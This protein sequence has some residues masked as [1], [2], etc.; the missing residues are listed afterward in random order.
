MV[1]VVVVVVLVARE[2]Q[3]AASVTSLAVDAGADIVDI[4]MGCPARQVTRGLSGSA[5]MRDLD[6]ALTLIEATVAASSV[7]VTL[8]MRLVSKPQIQRQMIETHRGRAQ[9]SAGLLDTGVQL[10]GMRR[11]AVQ[12]LESTDQ[13]ITIKLGRLSQ[14]I[15]L[16]RAAQPIHD[17]L[18][19][20]LQ[21]ALMQRWRVFLS[22]AKQRVQ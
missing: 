3:R 4:N 9:A 8:K 20:A 16:Q 13:L 14:F 21:A 6:H 1:V 11:L 17:Q 10:K 7:P 12:P 22:A 2:R 15:E 19:R 5:L 18:P